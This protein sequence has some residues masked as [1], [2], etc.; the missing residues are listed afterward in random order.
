MAADDSMQMKELLQQHTHAIIDW[1][2]VVPA[3]WHKELQV[4]PLVPRFFR[5][6]D[7][8]NMPVLLTLGS[9]SE[10]HK[11]QLCN[12]LEDAKARPYMNMLSSLLCVDSQVHPDSLAHHLTNLL[13]LNGPGREGVDRLLKYYYPAVFLHLLRILPPKRIRQLFGPIEIWSLPFQKEW[14]G[15]MP[16]ETTG[17]IPMYWAVNEEQ[18]Q[19]LARIGLLNRILG[20]WR[21]K[22]KQRWENVEAFHKDAEKL[23]QILLL[24]VHRYRLQV[25][26]DQILFGVH[27][28][29]Y[30]EDFHEHPKIQQILQT[31]QETGLGY[32]GGCIDVTEEDWAT[33]AAY[34]HCPATL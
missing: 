25:F 2:S 26:E 16:P 14:I 20:L 24:Y 27:F 32:T 34:R 13:M 33:I 12:N 29:L 17:A 21:E 3:D 11:Q 9:L 22:T 5:G 10:T 15:L 28:L 8:D 6:T 31:V 1:T 30:G 23:D 18:E 4:Q 19:R 7:D